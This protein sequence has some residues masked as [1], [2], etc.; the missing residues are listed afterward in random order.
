MKK[1]NYFILALSFLLMSGCA[2]VHNIP[3]VDVSAT[4]PFGDKIPIKVAVVLPDA[5]FVLNNTSGL[6]GLGGGSLT[7]AIP[8]GKLVRNISH[9]VFPYMFEE[10]EFV[11]SDL[12]PP[13]IDALLIPTIEDCK[14]EAEQVALGF[15]L[16]FVANVSL[17][18][19]MT[20]ETGSPIWEQ[21]VTASKTSRAVVSPIIPI[22]Q[23]KGE[24]LS[25]A[26]AEAFTKL[27][28]EI[29]FSRD[30][31]SY[32]ASKNA[33]RDKSAKKASAKVDTYATA[34]APATLK[35]ICY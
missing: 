26:V 8:A 7:E 2:I 30:I 35:K 16:K 31:K 24:A 25:E 15:G 6:G 21:V 5:N 17:K 23:L 33:P 19:V 9:S 27:A 34:T 12:H 32:A 28:R 13:G 22:E 14:F 4:P 10:V 29:R 11:Q 20:D 1:I 3:A 18:G